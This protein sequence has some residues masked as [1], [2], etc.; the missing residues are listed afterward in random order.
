MI[1]PINTVLFLDPHDENTN[2]TD[3]RGC[4]QVKIRDFQHTELLLS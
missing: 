1:T 3:G 2:V 4:K